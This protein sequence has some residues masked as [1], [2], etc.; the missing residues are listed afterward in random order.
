MAAQEDMFTVNLRSMCGR[1]PGALSAGSVVFSRPKELC[2]RHSTLLRDTP[3]R[4]FMSV[5]PGCHVR[6]DFNFFTFL[7]LPLQRERKNR[8]PA[9]TSDAEKKKI[10]NFFCYDFVSVNILLSFI[11]SLYSLVRK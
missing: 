10:L 9:D 3:G 5:P 8:V 6:T 1:P 7:S 2:F 11:I 4:F